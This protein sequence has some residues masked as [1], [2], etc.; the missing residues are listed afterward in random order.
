M[1]ATTEPFPKFW[2]MV[3]VVQNG[4]PSAK[5]IETVY[6][7]PVAEIE[8]DLKYHIK[9]D[10]FKRLFVKLKLDG[11]EK[12]ATQPA[13]SFEVR[14]VQ[15]ELLMGLPGKEPEAKR[16]FEELT[17]EDA[18]R[19][20]PWANLGYLALRDRKP[21]DAVA[22]FSKAFGL[23]NRNRRLL[24][25]LSRL[26]FQDLPLEAARALNALIELEPM[27]PEHRLDLANLH[28]SQLQYDEALAA[29]RSVTSFKTPDQRDRALYI[30]AF[31]AMKS[32]DLPQARTRAEE[33]KRLTTDADFARRADEILL[34]L[35]QRSV[36]QVAPTQSPSVRAST[37][38][39]QGESA[40]AT[41]TDT[42]IILQDVK[43]TLVE[44]V[45]ATPA[46]FILQTDSGRKTF[47][48]LQPDRLIVTGRE[49]GAQ[50]QCGAQKPAPALRLQFTIAPEG[51]NADG[52]VRAVHF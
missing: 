51:S 23:G 9:S 20:E 21:E 41:R 7:K 38:P 28:M 6:G 31:S 4:T 11:T 45:C 5:A 13:D 26:A 8:N 1:L 36:P 3:D 16:R 39:P 18:K 14:E 44:L 34:N 52:V 19:P 24:L 25:D 50:F 43:G 29:A 12:L 32:G 40:P 17:R 37:A 47:L 46:R 35:S 22:N 10:S 42:E 15:A 48:I 27:N 49:G 30:G 33:L 2:K